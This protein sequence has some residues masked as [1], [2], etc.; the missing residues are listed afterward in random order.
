MANEELKVMNLDKALVAAY[1]LFLQYGIDKVTKE[2]IA[3]ESGLSRKSIDRYFPNKIDYVLATA[4][5]VMRKVQIQTNASFP[6]KMLTS[7]EYTGLE[8]LKKYMFHIKDLFLGEPRLFA[9]YSEFKIFIYRNCDDY[10]QH[11]SLFLNN[12]GNHR[13]RHRIYVIG[14]EDGSMA[15][16]LD[17]RVEEE[18]FS[19]SYFG[20]L[21]NLALSY[22]QHS[23][24]EMVR[25]IDR[26]ISNTIAMYEGKIPASP[27]VAVVG[28]V[29]A[30]NR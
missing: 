10:E 1:N 28:S 6:E 19:E 24:D 2:M 9:L 12:S 25:Q 21:C 18:Y 7:G 22:T 30:V 26:R 27:L 11:Y 17:M 16:N 15:S 5:W 20:F 29:S 3:K 14:R 4:E 23:A 8:L 13:L